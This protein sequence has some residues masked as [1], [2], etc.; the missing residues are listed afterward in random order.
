[1]QKS[2]DNLSTSERSSA[3]KLWDYMRSVD[4]A[5]PPK[6]DVILVLGSVDTLPAKRAAELFKEGKGEIVMFT[7]LGGWYKDPRNTS[8]ESEAR[9]LARTAIAY[10][11][12]EKKI[13]VEEKSTNTG[14]NILFSAEMIR[15]KIGDVKG[16][17]VTHMPSSL[18]RDL[19]TLLAQWPKPQPDFYMSA[20]KEGFDEYHIKGY[21]GELTQRQVINSMM[22]DF[23]R[24]FYYPQMGFMVPVEKIKINGVEIGSTPETVKEAFRYLVRKGH[25]GPNLLLEE[26]KKTVR[27]V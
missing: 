14:E 10:G 8:Q 3:L 7:G 12:P 11:V 13:M 16:I 21:S 18:I 20:P 24:L 1:M 6:S 27:P 22:G 26:D 15:V 25:G 9:L 4:I 5:N 2:I 23:H 17:I 19:S